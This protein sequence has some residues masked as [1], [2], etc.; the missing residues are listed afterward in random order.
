MAWQVSKR[1][2]DSTRIRDKKKDKLKFKPAHRLV[3]LALADIADENGICWPK[4]DTSYQTLGDMAGIERRSAMRV[5]DDLIKAGHLFKNETVGRGHSNIYVVTIGLSEAEKGAALALIGDL[6][7]TINNEEGAK[8]QEEMVS[9]VAPIKKEMVTWESPGGDLGVTN[10]G[11]NGDLGVTHPILENPSNPTEELPKGNG[12]TPHLPLVENPETEPTPEEPIPEETLLPDSPELLLLFEKI[13]H[14]R[15][16]KGW[17]PT[18]QFKSI[19]QKQTFQEAATRLGFKRFEAGITKG[20][21]KGLTDLPSLVNWIASWETKGKSGAKRNGQK[22][23]RES[24]PG[25]I[26]AAQRASGDPGQYPDSPGSSSGVGAEP[27]GVPRGGGL[28][29]GY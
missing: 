10:S 13:N 23:T 6:G 24:E 20:L 15:K 11:L 1:V 29:A 19:E 14:N 9:S 3:L 27:A 8:D 22:P 7:V 5:I 18:K 12:A 21:R 26:A 2:W 17:G 4:F 25:I 16:L 28:L